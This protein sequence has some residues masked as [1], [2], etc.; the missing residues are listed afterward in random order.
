MPR[1]S[2][3]RQSN[4]YLVACPI[5]TVLTSF[6]MHFSGSVA[7]QIWM[8]SVNANSREGLIFNDWPPIFARRFTPTSFFAFRPKF[9]VKLVRHI[10]T[11][12]YAPY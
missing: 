10:M 9:V 8:H 2:S 1:V 5:D 12:K 6:A 4:S 7:W 3:G 11:T